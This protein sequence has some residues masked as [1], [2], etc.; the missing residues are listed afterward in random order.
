VTPLP[1]CARRPQ[2]IAMS[3]RMSITGL[4]GRGLSAET[5]FKLAEAAKQ[6]LVCESI[7][8]TEQFQGTAC[9]GSDAIVTDLTFLGTRERCA[10]KRRTEG[11]VPY[12]IVAVGA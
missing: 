12:P 3:A 9:R 11:G 6:S 8:G 1:E 4:A 5:F 10:R 2:V 7:V